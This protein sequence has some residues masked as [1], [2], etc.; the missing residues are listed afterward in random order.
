MKKRL[1]L[2]QFARLC[3]L[4]AAALV[5]LLLLT[6]CNLGNPPAETAGEE[7]TALSNEQ[8]TEDSIKKDPYEKILFLLED[9]YQEKKEL[10]VNPYIQDAVL[11]W[12]YSFDVVIENGKFYLGEVLYEQI[13]FVENCSLEFSEGLLSNAQRKIMDTLNAIKNL[14]G[15][16]LLEHDGSS[17]YGEKIAVCEI[18]GELYFLTFYEN[19]EITRIHKANIEHVG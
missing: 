14:P 1:K 4:L 19:G 7:T 16:Y 18:D 17:V 2:P 13:S 12:M 5:L 10:Q 8:E 6:G 11:S 3:R 15:Y 9:S